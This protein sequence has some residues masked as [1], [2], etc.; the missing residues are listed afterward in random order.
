MYMSNQIETKGRQLAPGEAEAWLEALYGGIDEARGVFVEP[1]G[2]NVLKTPEVITIDD[3]LW[4]RAEV[5][6]V[7][8]NGIAAERAIPDNEKRFLRGYKS[9]H[10]EVVRGVDD[11]RKDR[12]EFYSVRAAPHHI[13]Q[14]HDMLQWFMWIKNDL[15]RKIVAAAIAQKGQGLERVQWARVARI[16]NTHGITYDSMARRYR[17]AIERLV[18]KLN[19]RDYPRRRKA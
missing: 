9:N 11:Y 6:Q 1:T 14:F 7:L 18:L 15:D 3:F 12:E 10:P 16:T 2:P 4:T 8:I 5:E 19:S 13:D 17:R